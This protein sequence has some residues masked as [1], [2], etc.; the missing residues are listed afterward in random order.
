MI[1]RHDNVTSQDE[2]ETTT[3]RHAVDGRD[4]GLR[5]VEVAGNATERGPLLALQVTT[6]RGPFGRDLEVVPGTERTVTGAGENRHPHLGVVAE[7]F[8]DLLELEVRLQVEGVH[9]VGPVEGHDRDMV[10]LLIP[11][12]LVIHGLSGTSER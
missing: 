5:A 4:D 6:L 1:G 10:S 12:E 8:P 11:D 2:L 7:V 9:P 3:G